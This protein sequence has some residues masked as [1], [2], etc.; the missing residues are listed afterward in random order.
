LAMLERAMHHKHVYITQLCVTKC[1]RDA[2]DD[3]KAMLL[4]KVYRSFVAR[5]DKIELHGA[6]AAFACRIQR[7]RT[8]C[9]GNATAARI[10]WVI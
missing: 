4:P 1:A 5:D 8:H 10:G 6:E 7:V 9:V 2:A 3:G